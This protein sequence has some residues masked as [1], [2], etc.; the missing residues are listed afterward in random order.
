[1]RE[2]EAMAATRPLLVVHDAK[3][4]H[5][6]YDLRFESEQTLEVRHLPTPVVPPLHY[7]PLAV[8]GGTLLGVDATGLPAMPTYKPQF[9]ALNPATNEASTGLVG[10]PVASA[11]VRRADAVRSPEG[12]D[13]AAPSSQPGD[14]R[15]LR[16]P[17]PAIMVPVGDDTV[18]RMDTVIYS[19]ACRFE[20]LRRVPGG[21]GGWRTDPLPRPEIWDLTNHSD[22]ASI[23]AYFAMGAHVWIS[24]AGMGVFSLDTR[25]DSWRVQYLGM[26]L[27]MEGRAVFVPELSAVVGLAA[28]TQEL[29][30]YEF[31]EHREPRWTCML[32][33][34]PWEGNRPAGHYPSKEMVSLAYLGKGRFC[35]CRAIKAMELI[36]PGGSIGFNDWCSFLVL[37]LTRVPDGMLQ[38]AKRSE[39]SFHGKWPEGECLDMYLIQPDTL[40]TVKCSSSILL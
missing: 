2:K 11:A 31:S 26:D 16:D 27:R 36:V 21:G 40:E 3:A 9:R 25:T 5:L 23:T 14:P 24:V 22:S 6:V 12:P 20:A 8:A 35:I 4:G 13:C 34:A 29:C 10:E 7:R 18:I 30:T 28:G 38:L 39:L 32:S 15:V 1:M 17:G 33:S 19:D 37:E